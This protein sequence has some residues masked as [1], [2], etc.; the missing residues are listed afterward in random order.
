MCQSLNFY[1]QIEIQ[2]H[3]GK[4]ERR[5]DLCKLPHIFSTS[6]TLHYSLSLSGQACLNKALQD[7]WSSLQSNT[8]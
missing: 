3:S 7:C 5:E 1:I 4:S 6:F 8:L 2:F